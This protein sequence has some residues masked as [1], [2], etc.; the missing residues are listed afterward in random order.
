MSGFEFLEWLR[1]NKAFQQLPVAVLSTSDLDQDM[2]R[3]KSLGAEH[4]F[5]KFPAV[6]ELA[7]VLRPQWRPD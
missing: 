6:D 5:V 3:A 7:A 4:Y 2:E 1:G